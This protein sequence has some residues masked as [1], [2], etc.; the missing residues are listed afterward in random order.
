MRIY[1]HVL[2][3]VFVV[4][5]SS[6]ASRRLSPEAVSSANWQFSEDMSVE[7]GIRDKSNALG[8]FT[9]LFVVTDPEGI[10]HYAHARTRDGDFSYVTFPADF[11]TYQKGGRY[12]WKC[13]VASNAVAEGTFEYHLVVGD[14]YVRIIER[15]P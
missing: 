14:R 12:S 5:V 6:C 10:K 4:S 7:L 2:L 9:A 1:T 13:M 8:S 15:E 3:I 11:D